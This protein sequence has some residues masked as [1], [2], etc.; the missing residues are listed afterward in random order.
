MAGQEARSRKNRPIAI[1]VA[2][3]VPLVNGPPLELSSWRTG[4]EVVVFLHADVEDVAKVSRFSPIA[5]L[6]LDSA[7]LARM[8]LI[9]TSTITT[10]T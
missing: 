10:R 5:G 8:G 6:T 2:H 7:L 4:R 9:P 3:I 1:L